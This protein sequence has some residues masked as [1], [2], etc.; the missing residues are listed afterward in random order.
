MV[1]ENNRYLTEGLTAL[2]WEEFLSDCR[3][4]GYEKSVE[5]HIKSLEKGYILDLKRGDWS[6]LLSL[7]NGESKLLDIGSGWGTI[8]IALSK[9]CKQ[10]VAMDISEEKSR[11]V[12]L[13]CEQ[14]MVKNIFPLN[15]NALELPF[16]DNSFD[17]VVLNGVLEWSALL[18]KNKDPLSVQKACLN[19][20]KRVLKDNGMLYLAIENRFAATLL[21]GYKDEHTTLRFI[22]LLPRKLANVYSKVFLKRD[23]RTY[24]HSLRS[25]RNILQEV[26]FKEIIFFAPLPGYRD[27]AYL[28]PLDSKQMLRYFTSNIALPLTIF[29]YV[30]FSLA[31]L[32]MSFG[33]WRIVKYFVPDFSIFARK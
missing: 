22:T 12:K 13:R 9:R 17:L 2:G 7:N 27:F 33:F 28:I 11:F 21:L 29:G 30:F 24:T 10:V 15:A 8:S 20:A 4:Q 5:K 3:K 19:E 18:N 32:F 25:Y 23:Y 6:Y 1:K 16:A 14:D 26:G 31:K